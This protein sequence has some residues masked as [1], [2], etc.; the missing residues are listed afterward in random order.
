VVLGIGFFG[1]FHPD[2]PA[3]T[4]MAE[5]GV[6]LL[7]FETGIN[8]DLSQLLKVGPASLAVACAGVL[9]PFV[10]GSGFLGRRPSGVGEK[11]R[12]APYGSIVG[13]RCDRGASA[14][15]RRHDG[16]RRRV[17]ARRQAKGQRRFGMVPV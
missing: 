17:V 14:R 1:F 11:I 9:A 4:L 8:S 15:W 3:L 12:A 13:A 6:I 5:F 16:R 10:L 2:D 7:L